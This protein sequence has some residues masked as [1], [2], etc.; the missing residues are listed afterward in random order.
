MLMLDL[1]ASNPGSD[2]SWLWAFL[3]GDDLLLLR[4]PE[5]GH[6]VNWHLRLLTDILHFIDEDSRQTRFVLA[7]PDVES[8]LRNWNSFAYR[9][10]CRCRVIC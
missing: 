1:R 6:F 10:K 7:V 9:P 5:M 3:E 8:F 2:F 4:L